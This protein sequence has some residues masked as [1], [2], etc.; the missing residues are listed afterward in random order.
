MKKLI[1]LMNPVSGTKDKQ[2]IKEKSANILNRENR[3]LN[4]FPPMHKA[5]IGFW[6]KE[7][8]P[9]TLIL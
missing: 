7:S 6:N 3:L 8:R 9:G 1:F 4:L 2:R 5:I